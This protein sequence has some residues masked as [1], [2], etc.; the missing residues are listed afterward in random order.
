MKLLKYLF[1]LFLINFNLNAQPGWSW[2][3]DK[4]TAEEKNVLYTDYLKQG[5]CE[6]AIEPN[7]WLI[8]NV[9]NLHVSIYAATPSAKGEET[10]FHITN[11]DDA[12]RKNIEITCNGSKFEN[13]EMDN[14]GVIKINTVVDEMSFI[15][16]NTGY[17]K[18]KGKRFVPVTMK[19]QNV[20]KM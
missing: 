1:V 10:S 5:E 19:S 11:I 20:G 17:T 3:E 18:P 4:A 16:K 2:P 13:Y 9:P 6:M 8:Q 14:A 15:I 12:Q 7:R